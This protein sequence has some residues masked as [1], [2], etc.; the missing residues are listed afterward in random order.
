MRQRYRRYLRPLTRGPR[1]PIIHLSPPEILLGGFLGLSML[2]ACLLKLPGMHQEGLSWL[3]AL[4]TATSAVTVTGLS[5]TPLSE[6][7]FAGQAVVLVLIQLGG[8]G[9]M[10]IAALSLV[11]L[12]QR[13]P[14][15]QTSLLR[16]ALNRSSSREI[17]RLLRV[18]TAFAVTLELGGALLLAL[19]WVPRHGWGRGMWLSLFHSVSAFNNAGFTLWPDSL[20]R[21]SRNPLVASVISL[22]FMTG[23][24]GF[25]VIGELRERR[26]EHG[27]RVLLHPS[28][29]SVQTR[30]VL[31]AT[32]ALNLL[33]LVVILALE[34]GNP[35]T[36]AG[37]RDHGE[38]FISAA[39]MA[40]TP[41][42]AGFS[43]FDTSAMTQASTLWTMAMMFIGGGSGSTASGIKITTFV[44]LLLTT[45]A[46]L[47]QRHSPTLHGRR[48]G[49]ETVFKAIAVAL[50]GMLLI[51]SMLFGLT[52][53]DPDHDFRSLAFETVSAFGTVGLS[54]GVTPELSAPGQWL[55][56]ITMLLGRTGPLA[57][58]YLLATRSRPGVSYARTE[59]SI[60]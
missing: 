30:L 25:A 48:I 55:I 38:R 36:L 59:L 57:L 39:F 35:D 3:S 41:R 26:R 28:R 40:V 4:F 29:F 14:M 2:G 19:E 1:G 54:L 58:G 32:I 42:T 11:M 10:T 31:E 37:M 9:F 33:S 27:W 24:I 16:E 20:L 50:A 51:F 5:V 49:D 47:R 15:H 12:G 45:R 43:M 8:L 44:V 34:W 52:I 23:G 21:E 56:I 7:T 22:L 60:G 13:L 46:F 6:F 18:I 53:T 17:G